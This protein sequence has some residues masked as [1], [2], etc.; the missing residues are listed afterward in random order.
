VTAS[1]DAGLLFAG[2]DGGEV[3]ARASSSE[4]TRLDNLAEADLAPAVVLAVP[5]QYGAT[6]P[7]KVGLVARRSG[8]RSPRRRSALLVASID[9]VSHRLSGGVGG[10]WPAHCVR[11]PEGSEAQVLRRGD[12]E[13]FRSSGGVSQPVS[14]ACLTAG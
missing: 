12:S 8:S 9:D 3:G 14:V 5:D 10:D 4:A 7:V 2:A 13:K 1:G 11:T 6:A